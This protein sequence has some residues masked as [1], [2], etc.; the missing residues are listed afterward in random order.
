M[1]SPDDT[2]VQSTSLWTSVD[3]AAYDARWAAMEREG[4][5]IHGEAD[6]VC[7]FS[8]TTVLDGGCGT[9]RV[10]IEL[11]RRGCHVVGVDLD[12]PMIR[13]AQAKAPEID[14]HLGDLATCLLYTSP[15]PRDGATSR[16]PS[17]A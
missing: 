7:R 2:P 8:P 17:S 10:A 12:A 11:A 5:S 3:T 4:Q 9:G 13:A 15:S 6:F 14:F 16:M 1:S